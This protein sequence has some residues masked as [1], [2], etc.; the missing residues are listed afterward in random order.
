MP[1]P[2][3]AF[4][5]LTHL[6]YAVLLSL[7]EEATHPYE[8]V[9]RIRERS[10]GRIDPGTGS[11]YSVLSQAERQGLIRERAAPADSRRRVYELAPLGR[12]VLAAEA[13]RLA[14]QLKATRAALVADRRP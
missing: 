2:V 10:D 1:A 4:L 12:R 9:K 6:L 3:D 8:L 14:G 7:A 5:P 11:F 13:E